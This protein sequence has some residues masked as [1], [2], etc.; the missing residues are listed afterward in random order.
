LEE[1][2]AGVPGLSFPLLPPWWPWLW[3]WLRPWESLSFPL[4]ACCASLVPA[5]ARMQTLVRKKKSKRNR[6]GLGER[7]AVGRALAYSRADAAAISRGKDCTRQK[8]NN[9]DEEQHR[10]PWVPWVGVGDPWCRI[11]GW[12]DVS[13]T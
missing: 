8:E 11:D 3:L 5:A 12:M 9:N 4:S 2:A 6:E 1:D 7:A 13:A 10:K